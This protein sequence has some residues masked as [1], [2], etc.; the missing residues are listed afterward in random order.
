MAE[1]ELQKIGKLGFN[2]YEARTLLALLNTG[3]TTASNLSKVSKVP[4]PRTY[5]ILNTF[6]NNGWIVVKEANPKEYLLR[7]ETL[8][9]L[10]DDKSKELLDGQFFLKTIEKRLHAPVFKTEKGTFEVVSGKAV[11]KIWLSI[12]RSANSNLRIFTGNAN[13]A[14]SNLEVR[15]LTKRK[16]ENVRIELIAGITKYAK[17]NVKKINTAVNNAWS[18]NKTD[19]RFILAD[20]KRLLFFEHDEEKRKASIRLYNEGLADGAELVYLN[21]Y[22]SNDP[23]VIK[24]FIDLF[25]KYKE[26]VKKI[27]KS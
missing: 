13:W 26:T 5:E 24:T 9:V 8:K 19:L 23:L 12:A 3:L 6:A 18:L 10:I 14:N 4:T 15:T 1:N 2:E 7:P 17:Q 11:E 16:K 22:Y 20:K 27:E 21:G 25:E